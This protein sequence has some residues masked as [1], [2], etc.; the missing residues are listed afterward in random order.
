MDSKTRPWTGWSLV[1]IGIVHNA[2]GLVVGWAHI[3]DGVRGGFVGA[4]D[5]PPERGML[6]WFLA[7]GFLCMICGATAAQ[8]ERA[9]TPLSW[10]FITGLALL[11][12]CG[13]AAMPASGF[14]LAL[15]PVGIALAK[16]LT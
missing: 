7:F 12:V 11:T 16:K 9:G 4:W 2:F 6:F 1:A 8:V 15:V 3:A 14:W 10:A 13:I 5:S